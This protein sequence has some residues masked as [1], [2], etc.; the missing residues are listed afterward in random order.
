MPFRFSKFEAEIRDQPKSYLES[1]KKKYTAAAAG[2]PVS[3]GLSVLLGPLAPIGI[4]MSLGAVANASAKLAIIDN[5]LERQG[6]ESRYRVR[7]FARG[8]ATAGAFGAFGHGVSHVA[9]HILGPTHDILSEGY[10]L[11]H[12]KNLE[13]CIDRASEDSP[14]HLHTNS[15]TLRSPSVTG[16]RI[17]DGCY[18][19]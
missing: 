10:G 19:V 17:C 4:A 18:T 13:Y 3:A 14:S 5:E 7:D 16:R 11:F 9:N 8:V 2:S 6:Q 1:L 15:L 12:E